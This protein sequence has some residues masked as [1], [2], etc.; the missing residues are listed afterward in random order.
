MEK[1]GVLD[2]WVDDDSLGEFF[3]I[4]S[5]VWK[6]ILELDDFLDDFDD[7]DYEEDIFKCWGKGKF[8][9]KGVGSVCKKLDVF[10]LEDWDK[11]YVCD[12][13]GKCYK[14]WLGFSYYYVYFYLVEE[15]GEDKEDF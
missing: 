7:E 8:K 5:W 12:I 3:V 11:F 14:N 10:I 15:E 1:W 2:F 13:C 6:W 9:G 4:N